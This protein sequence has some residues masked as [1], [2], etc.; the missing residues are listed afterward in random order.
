[1]A[2]AF[3]IYPVYATDRALSKLCSAVVIVVLGTEV[4]R[5]TILCVCVRYSN[6]RR[7]ESWTRVGVACGP[8]TY[9]M[10]QS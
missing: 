9:D 4:Q 7:Q 10:T 5:R 3:T 2:A 1:M 8:E 6:I